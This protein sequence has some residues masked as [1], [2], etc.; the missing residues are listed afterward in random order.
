MIIDNYIKSA[1]TFLK[2]FNLKF[3]NKKINKLSNDLI[4]NKTL[5]IYNYKNQKVG[6]LN[7]IGENEYTIQI[8][9]NDRIISAI[10]FKNEKQES[11]F[12]FIYD[13]RFLDNKNILSGFYESLKNNDKIYINNE[14]KIYENGNNKIHVYINPSLKKYKLIEKRIRKIKLL[15]NK[16][17]FFTTNYKFR[18]TRINNDLYY[19][20][21]GNSDSNVGT[22]NHIPY[23]IYGIN[24]IKKEESSSMK[25]ILNECLDEYNEF[26]NYASEK[27]NVYSDNLLE[28]IINC[29]LYDDN[30]SKRRLFKCK[31]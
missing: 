11:N 14:Y 8:M 28:N 30:K 23:N 7:E 19:E 15:G 24:P 29:S 10:S 3:V 12:E 27:S 2:I 22:M 4:N 20:L 5:D 9:L 31:R 18:I 17:M 16:L 1:I 6:V 25:E 21:K 13:I 26:I